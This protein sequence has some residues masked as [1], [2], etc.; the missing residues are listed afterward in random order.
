VRGLT[1]SKAQAEISGLVY[2]FH[3]A[4]TS[5]YLLDEMQ[6]K[7][8]QEPLIESVFNSYVEEYRKARQLLGRPLA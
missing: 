2:R 5:R 3:F 8:F 6:K 4:E 1:A 7:S